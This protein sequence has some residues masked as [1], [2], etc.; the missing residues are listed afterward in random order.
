M[1]E[2][3]NKTRAGK[4]TTQPGVAGRKKRRTQ[5]RWAVLF[6]V[7][8][9][10][11]ALGWGAMRMAR[12]TTSV[13]DQ[14][15]TFTAQKSDLIVTVT[16]GGSIRAHNSIQY[17]CQ[18]ERRGAE[19]TILS[20]VPGGTYITQKDVDNGMVLV[21]LD[22]SALEDQLIQEEMELSGDKQS[23]TAEKESYDIQVIDN[24]SDIAQGKLDVR[25]ALIELQRYLGADLAGRLVKDVNEAAD[26]A[27]YVAPFVEEV[28][29]DP[30]LL[31]GSAAGKAWKE[32]QDGIVSAE[33][34]LKAA[35]AT[36]GPV[37]SGCMTPITSP[38][39][40]SRETGCR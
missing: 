27:K 17:K 38:I 18:V 21:E 36:L 40:N 31:E 6:V 11:A 25:F 24:E 33:G 32:A 16:E 1:K 19:V 20:I 5:R 14:G 29:S 7:I 13:T 12:P 35:E 3:Q 39:W 26:L 15:G 9:A 23:A 2:D 30:N 4:A 37:R 8:L 28:K 34:E 10:A 22:S